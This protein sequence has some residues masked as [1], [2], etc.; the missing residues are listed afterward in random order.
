MPEPHPICRQLRALR[1]AQ[2][3]SMPDF[4]LKTGVAVA[5]IGSHERG[6]RAFTPDT[7]A[8]HAAALGHEMVLR[9][10]NANAADAFQRGRDS[11]I[12]TF[13]QAFNIRNDLDLEP[14][15]VICGCTQDAAC[16]G[17][18]AWLPNPLMADLCTAC[19]ETITHAL[20]SVT[21]AGDH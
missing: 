13:C 20:T 19:A 14:A 2:G 4:A 18:C 5:T 16:E 9:P 7:L 11:A 1:L 17:G 8:E 10:I 3:M 21:P 6:T 12:A 15:C